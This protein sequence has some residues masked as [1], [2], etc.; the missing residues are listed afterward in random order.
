MNTAI[1]H[2]KL[3]QWGWFAGIWTASLLTVLSVG[4]GIK[5]LI[6]LI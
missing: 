2:K 1:K 5:F 4:Y 3:K 6:G